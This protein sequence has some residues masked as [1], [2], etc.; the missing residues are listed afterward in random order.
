[1]DAR[2]KRIPWLPFRVR[3]RTILLVVAILAVPCAW[4][5]SE[6]KLV[7]NRA[8]LIARVRSAG[9]FVQTD[10]KLLLLP[11]IRIKPGNLPQPVSAVRR[12]F[13]DYPV[14]Q[15]SVPH[16]FPDADEK[17]ILDLFPEAE[18][19]KFWPAS[20]DDPIPAVRKAQ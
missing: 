12:W 18:V 9:G 8:D 17:R 15:I 5:G 16:Q 19:V 3:L 10:S 7:R 11:S 2:Q 1:M 13:G 14:S 6:V 4:L 20:P